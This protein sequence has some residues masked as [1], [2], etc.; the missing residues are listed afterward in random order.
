MSE[1]YI[2]FARK[3][4]GVRF[5]LYIHIPFCRSKCSYCHF[6]SVCVPPFDEYFN[7]LKREL[8]F[9]RSFFAPVF[10][11][12]YVGGGTPSL[13]PLRW[14][15]WFV[16][17]CKESC[18][19]TVEVNPEDFEVIRELAKL[20]YNRVSVGI[21]SFNLK[22]LVF[23]GRSH[24]LDEAARALDQAMGWFENVNVDL[25]YAIPGQSLS[26][27]ERTLKIVTGFRPHHISIY[28]LEDFKG[29]PVHAS[30]LN[31]YLLACEFLKTYGYR[32]YEISNFS[33]PGFECRHNLKYWRGK[34]YLGIGASAASFYRNRRWKNFSDINRYISNTFPVEEIEVYPP[35]VSKCLLKI[36]RARL[37]LSPSK[38]FAS[39]R[40]FAE[41]LQRAETKA[42]QK[43]EKARLRLLRQCKAQARG[44]KIGAPQ[45]L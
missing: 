39:N 12:L 35:A 33:L 22:D 28:P 16:G 26:E 41:W 38:V 29:R 43:R 31:Y 10:D 8:G 15:E 30:P 44:H 2:S 24:G 11:T 19:K 45:L 23:L 27:W 9:W 40:F 32:R 14:H 18:E 4:L 5:G 25:I 6:Y 1:F 37:S 36:L 42:L 17:L 21:Q 7:A 3:Q 34:P 20:G 13:A